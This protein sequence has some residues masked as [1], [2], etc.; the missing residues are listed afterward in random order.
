MDAP[1][2]FDEHSL[3]IDQRLAT[4]LHTLGLAVI[5]EERQHALRTGLSTTQSS[6][7]A[8][9]SLEGAKTPSD[10]ANHLGV[11]LPTVSDSVRALVDK[12]LVK[13]GPDKGHR[14]ATLL[15]LT[16]T[17][18]VAGGRSA[19]LPEFL[20]TALGTLSDAQQEHLFSTLVLLLRALQENGQI[21]APRMCLTC[22]HFRPNV[23]AAARPHHCALVDAPMRATHLRLACDE[24]A[25]ASAESQT[26]QW[27]QFRRS[28]G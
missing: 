3:P 14:R 20:V 6:I 9:L 17:G 23:H 11:S 27:Q 28:A 4:G 26:T 25:M 24:H 5:L 12:G 22:T 15:T 10:V 7:L 13:R 16:R 2:F 18:R 8:L 1:G 19:S 21:P